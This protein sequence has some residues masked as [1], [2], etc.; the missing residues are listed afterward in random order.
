[1]IIMQDL[2]N[3]NSEVK[4]FSMRNLILILLMA[5]MSIFL[6]NCSTTRVVKPLEKGERQIGVSFGGPAGDYGIKT[7]LP[8]LST[9]YAQGV[10]DK[11]TAFGGLHLTS[12]GFMNI[13]VDAG[14]TYGIISPDGWRPGLSASGILNSV[15]TL[16]DGRSRLYPEI[17]PQLFWEDKK[18]IT[19]IGCA[20]WFD[21]QKGVKVDPETGGWVSTLN[22]GRQFKLKENRW[23]DLE[24]KYMGF[25]HEVLTIN[26]IQTFSPGKNGNIG[27][28]IGGRFNLGGGK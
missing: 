13:H 2:R 7:V 25:N 6:S 16:R 28:Y 22:L 12:L 15:T 24:I 18:G 26:G 14:V 10:T 3:L 11:L 5:G 17:T 23:L 27:F 9:S 21:L 1:M 20:N 8:L 4:K 19:F